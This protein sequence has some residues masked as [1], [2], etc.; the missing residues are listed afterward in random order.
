MRQ[1]LTL[2]LIGLLAFTATAKAK[3]QAVS[4]ASAGSEDIYFQPR[5]IEEQFDE[6]DGYD[7][8]D[9][10]DDQGEG[11]EEEELEVKRGDNIEAIGEDANSCEYSC[12]RYYRPVCVLRNGQPITYATPCEYHNQLRCTNVARRV[13]KTAAAVAKL[14]SFELMYNTACRD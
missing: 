7:G 5:S 6:S 8:D 14:P 1:T 9:D 3:E 11:E 13:A 2:V 10:D 12:P 4:Y